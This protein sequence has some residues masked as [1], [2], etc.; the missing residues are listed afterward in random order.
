MLAPALISH[1]SLDFLA[2]WFLS[3]MQIQCCSY[4]MTP[5]EI[6]IYYYSDEFPDEYV[7]RREEQL[8][9]AT[10]YLHKYKNGTL[11]NGT[12]K[13]IDVTLGNQENRI[14]LGILI[15]SIRTQKN[16]LITGP[17]KVVEHLMSIARVNSVSELNVSEHLALL[18]KPG[19]CQDVYSGPRIGLSDKYPEYGNLALRYATV[20]HKVKEPKSLK[21][22]FSPQKVN[23]GV[24]PKNIKNV[25][26]V[27]TQ[28]METNTW[29]SQSFLYFCVVERCN[30]KYVV[31]HDGKNLYRSRAIP[32]K[33][34]AKKRKIIWKSLK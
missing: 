33:N 25:A 32:K 31:V 28:N 26:C 16:V 21:L 9:W 23:I 29:Y 17:C 8:R 30:V 1:K 2:L 4:L 15:R 22:L 11:K 12:W 18:V 14:Y 27:E 6:E 13:G 34:V 24:Q 7:H 5:V 10:F 20:N 3:C 19:S